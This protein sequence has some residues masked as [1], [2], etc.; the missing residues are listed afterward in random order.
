MGKRK[1]K[2]MDRDLILAFMLF[3]NFLLIAFL[4][5]F[6]YNFLNRP[7]YEFT[8][9]ETIFTFILIP[10][11]Y[12]GL[13]S[14]IYLEIKLTRKKFFDKVIKYWLQENTKQ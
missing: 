3:L 10:I 14:L 8:T 5:N 9:A 7:A 11:A 4:S 13:I 12:F 2:G 1:Q 6:T